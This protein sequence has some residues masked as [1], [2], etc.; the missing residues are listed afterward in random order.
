VAINAQSLGRGNGPLD[1]CLESRLHLRSDA[2]GHGFIDG[3]L[4]V[5]EPIDVGRA[6]PE[7]FGDIRHGG[8]LISDLAKIPLRRLDDAMA[9][10]R[11]R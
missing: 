4:R 6:H 10:I 3:F 8:L 1:D 2:F 5:E 7:R 9:G 11:V